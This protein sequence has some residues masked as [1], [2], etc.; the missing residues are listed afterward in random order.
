VVA[1]FVSRT[2][3]QGPK[4]RLTKLEEVDAILSAAERLARRPEARQ[5]YHPYFATVANTGARASEALALR[6]RNVD[7]V[8]GEIRIDSSLG[9]NGQ[10]ES[11][12]TGQER[13]IPISPELVNILARAIP[14]DAEPDHF[15]FHAAGDPTTPMSYWN[16]RRRGLEPALKEAG[17]DG[18]GI[19]LHDFRHAAASHLISEGFTPVEVAEYLGHADASITLRVYSHLWGNPA[20]RDDRIRRAFSRPVAVD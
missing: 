1:I 3:K 5:D 16:V 11:T 2:A 13:T 15:V 7:L 14:A 10:I 18:R 4:I 12:K 17:L 8:T 19:T 9:R 20:E 6:V